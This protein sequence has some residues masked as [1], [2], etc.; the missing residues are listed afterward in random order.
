MHWKNVITDPDEIKVFMA[1]D[2]PNYTWRTASAIA[3]QTGLSEA[4]VWTVL[5]K[6]NM[7]LT[8]MSEVPSISGSALVGLREKIG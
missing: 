3:R 5:S 8:R 1:L 4:F 7:H 6:Y 2:G